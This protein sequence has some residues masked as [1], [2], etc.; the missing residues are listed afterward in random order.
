MKVELNGGFY[1]APNLIANA[2]RCLNLYPER[3]QPDA[4]FPFT[5]YLTPGLT[6]LAQGPA[7]MWR[8]LYRASTGDLY[9]VLGTTVYYIDSGWNLNALG[10]ID[11]GSGLVSMADNRLLIL[12]V[13]GTA[14]G[15]YIDLTNGRA[16]GSISTPAFYGADMVG[17]IDT[18]FALNQ[19]GTANWY[20]SA[21]EL[22]ASLI[23]GGSPGAGAIVGGANYS[24]G[25]HASVPLTGGSGQGATADITVSANAV[26]AVAIDSGQISAAY[27]VGDVLSATA[28]SL[29]GGLV[30]YTVVAGSGYTAGTYTG[31]SLTGG[32][33]LSAAATIVVS[34]G[35]VS[36]VTLTNP[37]LDYAVG[38]ALSALTSQIGGTGSGFVLNVTSVNASGAGFTYTLTAVNAGVLAFDSLDI[39]A[40]SGGSDSLVVAPPIHDEVWLIGEETTEVWT[41]AGAADF[42]FQKLP[43]IF[44][45]HGCCAKYSVAQADLSL[46]WLGRDPQGQCVVFRG[47]E[48]TARR[49]STHAIENVIQ[50][51]STVTDAIGFTY[52][53]NGHVFYV[54]TFPTADATW[55]FD[56]ATEMWHERAWID[57]NGQEH[58]HRANCAAFA[59][60]VNVVGDW[61]NGAL[62]KLDPAAQ[63]D[64]GQP[65]VRRRG[66]P[67]LVNEGKRLSHDRFVLEMDVG[68]IAQ[69]AQPSAA[70]A[71]E[72]DA[73]ADLLAVDA[74]GDVA[75]IDAA[76]VMPSVSL[77]WSDSKGK[78]WGQ[79]IQIPIGATGDDLISMQARQLGMAR[80]RVYEVFWAG[81]F[82]TALNG[83]YADVTPAET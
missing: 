13:D 75:A 81:D 47:T 82:V 51:Y 8:C 54:L 55:V 67:H 69:T 57:G 12:I 37:G 25:I 63:T 61:Q 9:G 45:Q 11:A 59:Y 10:A 29:G 46:F 68:T 44:I 74:S 2:Q 49:I 83:A 6:L 26:T 4:P 42:A 32:S 66:F 35:G 64:S 72:V 56:L 48:Y 14:N 53:Q 73:G 21:S 34:G 16:F 79:P 15:Y 80:D 24:N 78:R 60:G 30:G 38:D 39:A 43:G 40:K 50:G 7:G 70:D 17:Y 3:N 52:Q 1:V 5:T 23:L 41:D 58:R 36:S 18:F 77:R 22:T 33:G 28:L 31:V 65:I 20:L 27:Q 62:Y 71:L 76:V 19:P